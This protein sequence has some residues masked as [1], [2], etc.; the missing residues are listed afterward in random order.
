MSQETCWGLDCVMECCKPDTEPPKHLFIPCPVQ[1]WPENK[2]SKLN[3][4]KR[5]SNVLKCC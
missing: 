5:K 1:D 3:K 4:M 2:S